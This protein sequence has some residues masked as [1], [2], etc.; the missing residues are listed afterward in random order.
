MQWTFTAAA[1]DDVS[2]IS[3]AELAAEQTGASL[4]YA[5]DRWVRIDPARC[6]GCAPATTRTAGNSTSSA[7]RT[8]TVPVSPLALLQLA[9]EVAAAGDELGL[10]DTGDL[11]DV[12]GTQTSAAWSGLLLG[13]LPDTT[14]D[15]VIEPASF[16]GELRP[17]QRRG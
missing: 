5:G 8:V 13:G 15:E 11:D 1:D 6:A 17:Y 14:L 16:V 9:A 10:D 7:P 4:L 2:A 12:A 3:A